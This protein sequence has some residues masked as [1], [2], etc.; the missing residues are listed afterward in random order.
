MFAATVS[1]PQNVTDEMRNTILQ[2]ISTE[3]DQQFS[4]NIQWHPIKIISDFYIERQDI[5]LKADYMCSRKY[6]AV[7]L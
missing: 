7:L 2:K 5:E 1:A 4:I 6:I 3:L